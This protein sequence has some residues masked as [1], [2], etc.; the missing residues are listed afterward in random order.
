[1]LHN[2]KRITTA[3][4]LLDCVRLCINLCLYFYMAAGSRC[5]FI[6]HN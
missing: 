4:I 5:R 3:P 1:M 6:V 2:M